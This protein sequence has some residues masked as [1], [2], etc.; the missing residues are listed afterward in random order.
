M[1][2]P[3]SNSHCVVGCCLA[4]SRNL[5]EKL[6]G[7]DPGMRS[8]GT[9]DVDFGLKS[10]L[11]GHPSLVDPDAII[12]HRFRKETTPCSY[13]IP[14]HHDLLNRMAHGAE[15]LRRRRLARLGVPP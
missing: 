3:T 13:D 14:F 2:G 1:A 10:W 15:E 4:V 8:W 7:F 6:R 5:Y 11:M 9:E 12:G